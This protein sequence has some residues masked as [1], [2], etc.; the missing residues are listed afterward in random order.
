MKVAAVVLSLTCLTGAI[1]VA[2]AGTLD[3][4]K[5][6][7]EL[8][9]G[10]SPG[11][12]GFSLPDSQGRWSGLDVDLCR[13]VAAAIFNDP[14]KVKYIPLNPKDRFSTLQSGEIDVLSR[15]TT[16]TLSRDTSGMQFSPITYYD[17]QALMV[18][19]ASNIKVAK[20]LNGA[21]VCIQGGTTTEL[22]V[23]DYFRKNNIKYEPVSF[24]SGDEALK[25]FETG[26]CDVFT[27]DAS[28]LFAYRL[29][30]ANPDDFIVLPE[31]ISKE[32]LG[33]VVR[34]GDPE[35]ANVVRWAHFAMVNAEELGITQTNVDEQAK[36]ANP[37]VK[38][39][40]GVEG[41]LGEGL[42]LTPDW[43]Y[44]II[45]HVGNYGESFDRNV[46][47][48]SRLA[49]PRGLNNLWTNGGLQYAPPVR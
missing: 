45:K 36:S 42:G 11:V 4:V 29:K 41:K 39:F 2:Q 12:P 21:S 43:S 46:G 6:R 35:W 34:T 40:L 7:G 17:G 32:P 9:C 28:A 18:R 24:G 1:G 19:K 22:N 37:E 30:S 20:E 14:S 27:T 3:T 8:I 44:R 26:R 31:L 5:K 33:P 38:R 49:I 10:T 48:N 13:A 23:A 25:A 15:Q 47:P 16:W